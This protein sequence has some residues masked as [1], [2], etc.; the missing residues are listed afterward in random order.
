V[1]WQKAAPEDLIGLDEAKYNLKFPM[2]HLEAF[3][4]DALAHS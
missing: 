4:R 1:E 2:M 3:R